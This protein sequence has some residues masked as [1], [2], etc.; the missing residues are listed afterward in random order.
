VFDIELETI[1]AKLPNVDVFTGKKQIVGDNII[2][3]TLKNIVIY[4]KDL[5]EVSISGAF[6]SQNH[7]ELSMDILDENLIHIYAPDFNTV[8]DLRTMKVLHS[9][10]AKIVSYFVLFA[11][12]KL[13]ELY[14]KN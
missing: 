10:P 9:C 4:D 7:L 12:I 11:A 14:L 13:I 5:R 8:T 1:V 3:A 6:P 2:C